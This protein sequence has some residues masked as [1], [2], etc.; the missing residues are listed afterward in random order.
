M[1]NLLLFSFIALVFALGL[2]QRSHADCVDLGPNGGTGGRIID[3]PAPV[4]ATRLNTTSVPAQTTTSDDIVTIPNAGGV[5]IID[6][7]G[8]AAVTTSFGNDT[9]TVNG[10]ISSTSSTALL[11]S[12]D[13]DMLTVGTGANII[14]NLAIS[15][16][17]GVD[18][19]EVFD[20][21]ITGVTSTPVNTG[22]G[23]DTAI[24]NG[25][26]FTSQASSTIFM[27]DDDE[28]LLIINGGTFVGPSGDGSGQ[29]ITNQDDDTIILSG[30]TYNFNEI[31]AS[32]GDDTI[33]ITADLPDVGL[34]Q[35]GSN[36][37]TLIFSMG[38]PQAQVD[39]LTADF[40]NAGN[41]D[42]LTVNGNDYS[43]AGC[44]NRIPNFNALITTIS[45]TPFMATN[46]L[47]EDHTVT[48]TVLTNGDPESGVEVT[49]EITSGPNEGLTDTDTTDAN[50]E[51]TFTF[52]SPRLGMD[53]IVSTFDDPNLG[54]MSSN[55]VS[56]TWIRTIN[57]PTL[58]EWGLI[59]MAS[60]LGIVGFMVVRRRQVV[61]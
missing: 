60:L 12:T 47:L 29:I 24:I 2:S 4:Q 48:A 36:I 56:K 9:I 10:E 50:G 37:D 45:L 46:E 58:S 61:A 57:V 32:S 34:L 49:F 11:T 22:S 19:I 59:A 40:L 27:M 7:G 53:T 20:G 41:T 35:C 26:T 25:G 43:W 28:D 44:E 55:S 31:D 38:V 5:A 54:T 51:A 16:T 17:S 23:N 39:Q 52:T 3:C 18:L 33:H 42:G 13:N 14:G 21:N 1:K 15:M 6:G 30:G 8:S